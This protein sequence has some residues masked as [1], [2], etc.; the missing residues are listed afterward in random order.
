MSGLKHVSYHQRFKTPTQRFEECFVPVPE[1]GCWIWLARVDDN[2]YGRFFLERRI[3]A[4]QA[5]WMLYRGPIDN[6]CVLHKCDIPACVNPDHLYLGTRGNNAKDRV[7]R[8]RSHA[9]LTES[10]VVAIRRSKL[11]LIEIAM[12]YGICYQHASAVKNGIS[13]KHI[14]SEEI[15]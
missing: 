5:S 9:K 6:L 13:W 3:R 14:K 2:G 7:A 15:Q 10:D 1:S 4:H 12:E 11:S 8:G